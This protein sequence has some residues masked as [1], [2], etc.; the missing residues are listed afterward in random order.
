MTTRYPLRTKRKAATKKKIVQA[1]QGIFY[2]KGY[3]A[4]TLEEI[5]DAAGVHVQ[6]LY[7]HFPNKQTLASHGDYRWFERFREEITDPE[8][9]SNTFEFWRG[10][11]TQTFERLTNDGGEPYRQYITVR[12]ANPSILGE[13]SRIGARYEDLLCFSLAEDFG[14]APGGPG[15]PRLVAGML[16]AGSNYIFRRFEVEDI[17]LVQEA[18]AVVDEVEA[19]FGHLVKDRRPLTAQARSAE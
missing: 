18:V 17:D 4:T 16:L 5:A 13:M 14:M 12:H 1:A 15:K 19:M 2:R 8:R 3:D 9:T 7:R 11:L 10:W 6:T